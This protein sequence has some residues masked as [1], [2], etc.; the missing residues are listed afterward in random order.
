MDNR[1]SSPEFRFTYSSLQFA[2]KAAKR[3][4]RAFADNQFT[5]DISLGRAMAVTAQLTGHGT[6]EALKASIDPESPDFLDQALSGSEIGERRSILAKRLMKLQKMQFLHTAYEIIDEAEITGSH[7]G[8]LRLDG[9]FDIPFHKIGS[10]GWIAFEQI[11]ERFPSILNFK[12]QNLLSAPL[13]D[14][15]EIRI[16]REEYHEGFSVSKSGDELLSA[17]F[18]RQANAR[19]TDLDEDEDGEGDHPNPLR[20]S[21]IHS[22]HFSYHLTELTY[23]ERCDRKA[24]AYAAHFI[25]TDIIMTVLMC[26]LSVEAD[27]LEVECELDI[28]EERAEMVGLAEW[29]E[30]LFED[31]MLDE[32]SGNDKTLKTIRSR[33]P[34]NQLD[35]VDD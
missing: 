33:L 15:L 32:T 1:E 12:C 20:P 31:L 23:T 21:T 6:W 25:L 11:V 22:L 24:V 30:E 10:I 35:V 28:N 2:L 19:L 26:A 8:L 16:T 13:S 17:R 14:D 18:L 5:K 34:L 9:Y 7:T 3:L 27:I 29:V 4:K